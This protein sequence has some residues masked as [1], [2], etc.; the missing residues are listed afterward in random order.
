MAGTVVGTLVFAL[1]GWQWAVTMLVFFGSSSLLSRSFKD[2]RT[3]LA[4]KYA[5]GARR[6]AGQVLGN[7]AVATLLV[8]G[9]AVLPDAAWPWLGYCAALA[10]VNA[11]TWA[12]E[13]GILARS[14][15][16]LITDLGRRVERGTSGAVSLEGTAA[17]FIG[18]AL[19]GLLACVLWSG[20]KASTF[21]LI[22]CAG[23]LASLF[24]SVLG[25]TVQAMYFCT[26]DDVETEQHPFHRCGSPTV[27]LRGW[28]WLNNDWVNFLSSAMAALLAY[29]L[30]TALAPG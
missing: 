17:A 10:A 21:W 25:A 6:D 19:I 11:D 18:S 29:G 20:T 14:M 3:P 30:S 27:L 5:K 7:G 22:T 26:G 13:L 8:L 28:Q 23:F 2:G 9:H 1:G 16:R 12:T 4:K 24:D 15:P